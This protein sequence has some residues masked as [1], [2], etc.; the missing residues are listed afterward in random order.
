MYLEK[1][2]GFKLMVRRLPGFVL[3]LLGTAVPSE[4]TA[5]LAY[6]LKRCCD[7][8]MWSDAERRPGE[9]AK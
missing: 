3:E 9:S 7:Q 1:Q 4:L 8:L 6:S 2:V 5:R